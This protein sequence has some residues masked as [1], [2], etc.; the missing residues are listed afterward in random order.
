MAS[1][2][3]SAQSQTSHALTYR[4]DPDWPK[5]PPGRPEATRLQRRIG[6]QHG[7]VAASSNGDVY[8]SVQNM[9]HITALLDGRKVDADMPL[10]AE[11]ADPYA[12]LQVY[13]QDGTYLRNVP[14]SP[15]DFH[16]FVIH[17][18][19]GGEFIYGAR[20]A[21]THA[22]LDQTKA[23]WYREAV[24]KMTL[25]GRIVLTIPASAVPE[26]F[27]GS[28]DGVPYMRFT[29][30]AVG[31]NGDIYLSDGYSSD[32]IHRFDQKGHYLASFGGK[33]APYNFSTIHKLALDARFS[34]QR[35]IATDRANNRIVHLSLDGDF[36]GVVADDMRLPA[37]IAVWNEYAV[38]AELQGRITVIDKAGR[39]VTTLGT[40]TVPDEQ[41]NRLLE[42]ARWRPGI[43]TAPHGVAVNAHGDIFVSEL[44]SFGRVHRF[45]RQ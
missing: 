6:Y 21:A 19:S 33:Q 14:G 3:A 7:D 4:V 9:W 2:I 24:V 5:L 15:T 43:V 28:R 36:L 40:N 41:A 13:S 17:K 38:V 27:R 23:D 11:Y 44:N 31:P 10:P 45:N 29:D 39:V 26:Q 8:V 35:L 20:A 25:S 12:G 22:P 42:P 1:P 30:V 32:Y 37:A 16:G 18:E 34:P